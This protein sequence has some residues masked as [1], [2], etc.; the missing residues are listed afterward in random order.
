MANIILKFVE[1]PKK[2]DQVMGFFKKRVFFVVNNCDVKVVPGEHWECF[3]W[4][5]KPKFSLVKPYRKIEQTQVDESIK[6]VVS[7]ND[8]LS[9]IESYMKNN[10]DFEKI[11]FDDKNK[12][13]I[14]STL[15]LKEAREKY[16]SYIV[17]K[18]N[19]MV[20]I[21]PILDQDDRKEWQQISMLK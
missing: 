5:E 8:A 2:K 21:R 11:I 16:E 19:D 6:R 3:I 10:P 17:K 12:P 15:K 20:V 9:K 1:N 18:I 4:A 14:K 7:F 13:Y